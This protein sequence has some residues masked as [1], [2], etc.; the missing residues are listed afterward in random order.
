MIYNLSFHF[1]NFISLIERKW[2]IRFLKTIKIFVL[3]QLIKCPYFLDNEI[4]NIV[5]SK[6]NKDGTNSRALKKLREKKDKIFQI[7][8]RGIVCCILNQNVEMIYCLIELG[9]PLE[10]MKYADNYD[11]IKKKITK[12]SFITSI[13][14]TYI[15]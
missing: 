14:N 11:L 10:M 1:L 13:L 4:T 15:E 5:C 2:K 8:P 6:P 9:Y 7:Y 12:D 3:R